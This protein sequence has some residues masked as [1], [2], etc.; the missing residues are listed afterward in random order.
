MNERMLLRPRQKEEED[1]TAAEHSTPLKSDN[2]VFRDDEQ[3]EWGTHS[4]DLDILKKDKY[5]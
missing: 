2:L 3:T 1:P 5:L 4:P